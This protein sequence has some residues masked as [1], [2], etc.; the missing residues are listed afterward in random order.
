MNQK[1]T[2]LL[3]REKEDSLPLTFE[4]GETNEEL[5]VECLASPFNGEESICHVGG[6]YDSD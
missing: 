6:G 5:I 1:A 4:F 2:E 3:S